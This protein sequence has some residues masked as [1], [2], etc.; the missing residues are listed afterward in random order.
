MIELQATI[1]TSGTLLGPPEPAYN[2]SI[3]LNNTFLYPQQR[4]QQQQHHHQEQQSPPSNY[5]PSQLASHHRQS[6]ELVQRQ[7]ELEHQKLMD[8]VQ[9]YSNLNIDGST[10][11]SAIASKTFPEPSIQDS[12]MPSWLTAGTYA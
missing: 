7:K 4:Q 9:D 6:F 8:Q 1:S 10:P 11:L 5:K 2:A 12:T 3:T